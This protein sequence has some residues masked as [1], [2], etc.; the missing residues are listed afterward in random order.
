MRDA[1]APHIIYSGACPNHVSLQ[2][3][4]H[5][6]KIHIQGRAVSQPIKK[7]KYQNELK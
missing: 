3:A 6:F 4:T 1:K 5:Y 2:K 7:P